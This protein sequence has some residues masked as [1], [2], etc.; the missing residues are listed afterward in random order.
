MTSFLS[1]PPRVYVNFKGV[2]WSYTVK[3]GVKGRREFLC[4]HFRLCVRSYK[5]IES[6]LSGFIRSMTCPSPLMEGRRFFPFYV[7]YYV[8]VV[9][10]L[11]YRSR[12]FLLLVDG[13]N[14]TMIIFVVLF[15]FGCVFLRR[16]PHM[17]STKSSSLISR[18]GNGTRKRWS[19]MT[20]SLTDSYP[21]YCVNSAHIL[22]P[23]RRTT[24]TTR[25]RV[26]GGRGRKPRVS[27]FGN[28]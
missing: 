16:N 28:L 15:Y 19:S 11:L 13:V 8:R 12:D 22:G 4:L 7:R 26:A 21:F 5:Y 18:D 23:S 2:L 25:G 17:E 20:E 14:D 24:Y 27:I 9:F 1:C 6:F 10:S 3:T